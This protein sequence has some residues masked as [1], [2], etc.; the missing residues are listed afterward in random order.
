MIQRVQT[1][2]LFLAAVFSGLMFFFPFIEMVDSNQYLLQF[3]YNGVFR[4][5]P[6]GNVLLQAALPVT[7]IISTTL[8]LSL[9]AIFLYKKRVIQMRLC[10]YNIL[11]LLGSMGLIYYYY[12]QIADKLSIGEHA[13]RLAFIFPLVAAILN[14]LA[15][16]SI[17]RDEKLVKSYDRIR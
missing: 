15:F 10:I 3:N 7:I 8:V 13:F 12:S 16:R 5:E 2:Y 17:R 9:L 14:F 6:D 11:L 4:L 1:V